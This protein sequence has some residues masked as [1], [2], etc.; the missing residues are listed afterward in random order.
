MVVRAQMLTNVVRSARLHRLQIMS[1]VLVQRMVRGYRSVYCFSDSV[2]CKWT[3]V[4]V[5]RSENGHTLLAYGWLFACSK[6]GCFDS[7]CGI[8]YV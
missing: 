6:T 2:S 7:R 1:V 5:I 8:D 3:S 4:N